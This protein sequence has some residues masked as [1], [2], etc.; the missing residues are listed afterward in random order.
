[1]YILSMTNQFV[2]QGTR[3]KRPIGVVLPVGEKSETRLR[4]R[5]SCNLRKCPTSVWPV[6]RCSCSCQG[7][8]HGKSRMTAQRRM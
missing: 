7:H 6:S 8:N 4:V 1:M 3:T 2:G 5:I